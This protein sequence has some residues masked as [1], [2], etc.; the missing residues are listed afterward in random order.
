[1]QDCIFCKIAKKEIPTEF[2]RET[3]HFVVFKDIKPSAA[4]HLLIVPKQHVTDIQ[5][6]SDELWAEVKKIALGL[7][8]EMRLTGYRLTTNAGEAALVKHFHVHFL[9]AVKADRGL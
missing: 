7:G 3:D 6:V 2:V 1:M 4:I 5:G 9:G 8:D